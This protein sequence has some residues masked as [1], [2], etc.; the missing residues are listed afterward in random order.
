MLAR[1]VPDV[2]EEYETNKRSANA[3]DAVDSSYDLA[4]RDAQE[5][6]VDDDPLSDFKVYYEARE[7]LN[8]LT[9]E[10]D[11]RKDHDDRM[12]IDHRCVN[13]S[14]DRQ[15]ALSC[16]AAQIL[17]ALRGSSQSGRSMVGFAGVFPV[18]TPRRPIPAVLGATSLRSTMGT[19]HGYRRNTCGTR[20][21]SDD[22][23]AGVNCQ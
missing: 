12:S 16:D 15:G 10:R 20:H 21:E 17:G 9:I 14:T 1:D 23:Y 6:A 2:A 7:Q 11:Y 13:A 8:I 5:L 3:T 19:L 18:R 4:S 22:I